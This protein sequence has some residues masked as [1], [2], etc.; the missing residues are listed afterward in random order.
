MNDRMEYIMYHMD[1]PRKEIA[2]ELGISV[3]T[4][5]KYVKKIR[6]GDT[7]TKLYTLQDPSWC[8][9][10]GNP[11]NDQTYPVIS[12][13]IK[14]DMDATFHDFCKRLGETKGDKDISSVKKRVRELISKN[15]LGYFD[16][17]YRFVPWLPSD[18][19]E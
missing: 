13:V 19:R 11:K 16:L 4:V 8:L 18:M 2:Y 3:S 9:D 17:N 15:R 14:D 12:M 6:N 7:N 1:M 10:F 5:S